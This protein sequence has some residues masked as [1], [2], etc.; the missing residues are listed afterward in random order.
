MLRSTGAAVGLAA[1]GVTTVGTAAAH[2][3][4]G[5][6]FTVRTPGGD[7]TLRLDSETHLAVT[8]RP[9]EEFDPLA[10]QGRR[11]AERYRLGVS[12]VVAVDGAG[13]R[14]VTSFVG[15]DHA[16]SGLTLVFPVEGTGLEAGDTEV[17][18]RWERGEVGAHHGLSGTASLTVE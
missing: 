17:E 13:A 10:K 4:E 8:V 2:F 14:P 7:D 11:I 1:L 15:A 9:S 3:P 18:L 12:D 6:E 16:D 5:L